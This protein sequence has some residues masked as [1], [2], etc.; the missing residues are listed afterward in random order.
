MKRIK[1]SPLCVI[2]TSSVAK[3]PPLETARMVIEGGADVIQLREKEMPDHEFKELA[4]QMRK[5]TAD[6]GVLFIVNDR[7][8]IARLVSAD[9]AHVGQDDLPASEARK[10]LGPD[11]VIGVSTHEMSQAREALED[12]ADYIGAGPVFP[13]RTKGYTEGIG[14]D[15][16]RALAAEYPLPFFAIGGISL[17]NLDQVIEAGCR[18]VAVSSAIIAADDPARAA[19]EFK[20]KLTSIG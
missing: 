20:K 10:I 4:E 13:T 14:T 1:D 12:G 17:D 9:G 6:A 3:H 15:Y 5:L 19:R 2:V 18:H 7:V 8:A 11:A 16:L